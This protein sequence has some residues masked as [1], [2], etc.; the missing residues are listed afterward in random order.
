MGRSTE[1][2][3][4]LIVGTLLKAINNGALVGCILV[5]F[6]KDFDLV[7]HNLLH[8]KLRHYK[9]S[10]MRRNEKEMK[11]KPAT[12]FKLCTIFIHNK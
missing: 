1:S 9:L 8:Q 11:V 12:H 10:E 3:L 6:R 4:T 5:D 7:D 2:A